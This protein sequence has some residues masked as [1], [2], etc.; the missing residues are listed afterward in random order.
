MKKTISRQSQQGV[1]MLY[2][3][4]MITGIIMI[5]VTLTSRTISTSDHVRRDYHEERAL[6]VAEGGANIAERF[7]RDMLAVHGNPTEE[8]LNTFTWPHVDGF[9]IETLLIDKQPI[10]NDIQIMRGPLAGLTRDVQPFEITCRVANANGSVEKTVVLNV[11]QYFVSLYQYAMYWDQDLEIFP[12]NPSYFLG[13]V[14]SNSDLYLGATSGVLNVSGS[15]TAAGHIYNDPKDPGLINAGNARIANRTGQW[16]VLDYD[17]RDPDWLDQSL[18]DW[19]WLVQDSAHGWARTPFP[20]RTL[21]DPIEILRRGDPISDGPLE[22]ELRFRYRA[23][24]KII[25]GVATDSAGNLVN[26]AG[27][28]SNDAVMD[29]REGHNMEMRT[30]DLDSMRLKNL[31][32]ENGVIYI[33]YNHANAAVRLKNAQQLPEGGLVIATDNPV[34]VWGNYNTVDKQPSSIFCDAYNQYSVEWLDSRMNNNLNQRNA[35][36]TFV[37]TC[38]VAGNRDTDYEYGGGADNLIRLHERWPASD[39]LT[40]RGSLCCLWESQQATGP[41]V[42]GAPVFSEHHRNSGID[43]DLLDP[44]F[45]P[46]YDF[47]N[48]QIVRASW[49]SF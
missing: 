21:P 46:E 12:S 20:I 25:D 42:D 1:V 26:L 14:H 30:F 48:S 5:G 37:N 35:R 6:N 3:L 28:I 47:W 36:N 23:G 34:Y 7:L 49:Q 18:D 22:H 10:V 2:A 41:F 17:S 39:Q 44:E 8:L 11:E 27:V 31:Y 33:S 29:W 32:P 38:I 24:L 9:T 40:Y 16:I 43:P 19:A 15:V 45:W 4:L 13:H